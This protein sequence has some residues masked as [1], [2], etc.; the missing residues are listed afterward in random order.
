MGS[1]W[2]VVTIILKIFCFFWVFFA[3]VNLPSAFFFA[4]CPK[5][6][7]GKELFADKMLVE[8]FLPSVKWYLPSVSA[9]KDESGSGCEHKIV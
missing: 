7:L 2:I 5:K 6:L 9:K 1:G 4:E 3:I 8:Y